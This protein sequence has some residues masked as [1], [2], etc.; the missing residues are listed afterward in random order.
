MIRLGC[1]L[2]DPLALQAILQVTIIHSYITSLNFLS[3]LL[4]LPLLE[5]IETAR[6]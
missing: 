4:F 5:L 6:I 3:S 1:I 2:Y